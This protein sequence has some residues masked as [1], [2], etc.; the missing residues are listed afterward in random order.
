MLFGVAAVV[1]GD[2]A[3]L[4]AARRR[5]K[6]RVGALAEHRRLPPGCPPRLP[7]GEPPEA[8]A[9]NWAGGTN[10]KAVTWPKAAR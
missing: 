7:P 9:D 6:V 10:E 2:V 5:L 1:V 4:R 8:R 3:T